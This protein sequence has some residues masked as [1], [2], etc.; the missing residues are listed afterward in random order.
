MRANLAVT[1]LIVALLGFGP[2]MATAQAEAVKVTPELTI[3]TADQATPS[4]GAPTVLRGSATRRGTVHAD[5]GYDLWLQDPISG[6]IIP[7]RV[8][9]TAARDGRIIECPEDYLPR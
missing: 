9:R 8:R 6:E 4:Y 1:A 5:A 7:C 3:F 2:T